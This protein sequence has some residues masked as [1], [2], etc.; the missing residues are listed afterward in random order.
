MTNKAESAMN[1][2]LQIF[3]GLS[4]T[5]QRVLAPIMQ[6]FRLPASV[7]A[8]DKFSQALE[9]AVRGDQQP[10]KPSAEPA[11]VIPLW[12]AATEAYWMRM[13]HVAEKPERMPAEPPQPE[14][15]EEG[16]DIIPERAEKQETKPLLPMRFT[17]GRDQQ[18]RISQVVLESDGGA[19]IGAFSVRRG[20]DGR[21]TGLERQ[22]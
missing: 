9:R 16:P 22:E 4:P 18:Q 15:E 8:A 21:I 6:K 13:P 7:P 12:A 14:L 20:Y 5:H 2:A 10:K 17:F 11:P 3:N 19:R 1:E